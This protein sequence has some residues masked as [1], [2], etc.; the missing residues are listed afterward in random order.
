MDDNKGSISR[1]GLYTDIVLNETL[2][3]RFA[4]HMAGYGK[5]IVQKYD[6]VLTGSSDVGEFNASVPS[7]Q[8]L[9][10]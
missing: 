5:E 1:E 2:C 9:D 10:H 8:S 6:K 7:S 3:E 4:G